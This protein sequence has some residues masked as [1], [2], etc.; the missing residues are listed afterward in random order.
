MS[1]RNYLRQKFY[2]RD[3]FDTSSLSLYTGGGYPIFRWIPRFVY[4]KWDK[5][6]DTSEVRMYL[7][8]AEF[9][10]RIGKG[11]GKCPRS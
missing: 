11:F 4:M 2:K 1:L 7:F 9:V 8:G 5:N 6:W 3:F 10:L